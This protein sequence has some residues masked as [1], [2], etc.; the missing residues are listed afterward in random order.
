[1]DSSVSLKDQIWFL[2]VCHH[3]S[4][5]LYE[6]VAEYYIYIYIYNILTIGATRILSAIRHCHLGRPCR[7]G[8]GI[9]I[10]FCGRY[11]PK[12]VWK[13][14]LSH[15]TTSITSL[16]THILDSVQFLNSIMLFWLGTAVAFNIHMC[17]HTTWCHYVHRKYLN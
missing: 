2:C 17:K 4:N 14:P 6:E 10:L 1:M 15:H 8:C 13:V 7:Y 12:S 3:I 9:H 5:M 16:Y 11:I